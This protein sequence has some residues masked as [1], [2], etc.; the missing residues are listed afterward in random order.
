MKKILLTGVAGFIG[1]H[2]ADELV[3]DHKVVGIDNFLLGKKENIAHLRSSENF[4]F[5]ATEI[6]NPKELENVFRIHSFDAIFHLAANSDISKGDPL[7]D[8]QNTF[9]TTYTLLEM[10]R[11]RKI[12]EFVFTSSGAIYGE[13]IS[14]V[15]ENHGPLFPISHYGAAKLASEAF[16]SSYSS[17]YGIK[18][19]I[20]RLPNVIGERMTHGA[21]FDFVNQIKSSTKELRVLG[22]GSQ[23]KPYMYVK[24]LID[25]ILFI[26]QNAN[27]QLNYFN[28]SGKGRTSVREI[29]EM[30][31]LPINYSGGDRGWNGD[32]PYYDCDISKLKNLGWSPKRNSTDAVRL[33]IKKYVKN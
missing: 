18:S 26:Y 4:T 27:D 1:S 20:L 29:A 19:W 17:M 33:T 28:I 3:K 31:N 2:L 7:H 23:T 13:T 25:A 24:D 16:I 14:L 8:L 11:V 10:C 32:S 15:K 5:H 22:D 21:I 12:K 9:A 6:I 30:F